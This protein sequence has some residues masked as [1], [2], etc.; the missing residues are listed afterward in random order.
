MNRA[1]RRA[2]THGKPQTGLHFQYGHNGTGTVIQFSRPVDNIVLTD[3]EV[4]DMCDALQ[5]TRAIL[6]EHR[7]QHG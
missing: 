3:Q 5:K 4:D 1:Q 2:T 6:I 7:K